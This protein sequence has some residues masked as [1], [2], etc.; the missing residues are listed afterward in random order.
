MCIIKILFFFHF[1]V[2]EGTDERFERLRLYERG[3]LQTGYP[4]WRGVLPPPQYDIERENRFHTKVFLGGLP[5]D[6]DE[7]DLREQLQLEPTTTF[8]FPFGDPRRG[9]AFVRFQTSQE[10]TDFLANSTKKPWNNDSIYRFIKD[11]SGETRCVEVIP[12]AFESAY[13]P[14][15]K[16]TAPSFLTVLV[17]NVHGSLMAAQLA[18]IFEE[19]FGPVFQ[20]TVLT[21]N[22]GYPRELAKVTFKYREA[23][24]RAVTSRYLDVS[25]PKMFRRLSINPYLKPASCS[26]CFYA[27][28]T[29]FCR[30]E[31]CL[32]YYCESCWAEVHMVEGMESHATIMWT[33]RKPA[34]ARHVNENE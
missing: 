4:V 17:K 14:Q 1:S 18:K 8:E 26:K 34:K 20:V 16:R 29:V 9:Y 33:F 27:N 15:F 13:Y 10:V 2:R 19:T 3:F 11:R 23:Y 22:D 25:T 28:G 32:L 12:W 31:D 5:K 21:G 7:Q 24:K 30:D 6:T